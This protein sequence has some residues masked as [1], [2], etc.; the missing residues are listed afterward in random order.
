[1]REPFA[2]IPSVSSAASRVL[3]V[4]SDEVYRGELAKQLREHG[5]TVF[6]AADAA[7]AVTLFGAS[8]PALVLTD[9][10]LPD[11][12]GVSLLAELRELDRLA[13]VILM[14]GQRDADLIL[15]ALRAGAVNFFTKPLD[16][17]E[18]V[19]T[20]KRTMVHRFGEASDDYSRH[21]VSERKAF[22]F[23]ARDAMP[24]PIINQIATQ[25]PSLV[26]EAEIVN[27]KV[28]VEEMVLNAIEY[29]CLRIT[30]EAKRRAIQ[31]GN[32][33]E[34]Y[35]QRLHTHELGQRRVTIDYELDVTRLRLLISDPGDGFDWRSVATVSP[36]R[37]HALTGRGILLARMSFDEMAYS[38]AGNQV[39]LVKHRSRGGAE[40]S[41]PR[42][43]ALPRLRQ[44]ADDHARVE[45]PRR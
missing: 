39:T 15:R 5:F 28:G 32:Y 23:A 34:L 40:A 12:D 26:D 7:Q 38:D 10:A 29:G 36:E 20:I 11:V 31:R 1:M 17:A 2:H 13:V 21:L 19:D 8:R 45:A 44:P 3:L 22:A 30:D 4:D 25:L 14:T 33:G 6:E 16:V 35:R 41:V 9:V 24:T 27:L 43:I 37:M 42:P 18:L